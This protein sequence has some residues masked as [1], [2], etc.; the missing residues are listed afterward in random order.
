MHRKGI[1]GLCLAALLLGGCT[2][3]IVEQSVDQAGETVQ[4]S[5]NELDKAAQDS[6]KEDDK[7]DKVMEEALD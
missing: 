3:N 7:E 1:V 4:D 6:L 5:V 2:S